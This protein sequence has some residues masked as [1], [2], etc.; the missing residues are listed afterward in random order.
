MSI[1]FSRFNKFDL[2]AAIENVLIPLPVEMTFNELLDAHAAFIHSYRDTSR[3][4]K[5]TDAFGNLSAWEIT[6]AQ[7]N[8]AAQAMLDA[9]Y[10]PATVNRDVSG[11]GSCYR[12]AIKHHKAPHGFVSPT[13]TCTRYTETPRI[14]DIDQETLERLRIISKTYRDKRFAVY[15]HLL[16]DTGA[17]AG[18]L[19]NRKWSD[20]NNEKREILVMVTKTDKPRVLFYSPQTAKLIDRYCP[21]KPDDLLIFGSERYP[22][23]PKKYRDNWITLTKAAGCPGLHQ[24]DLRHNRAR[25][26]L[27]NG[28]SLPVASQIM[29]HSSNMLEK[30]YGHLNNNDRKKAAEL[31]W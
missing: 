15:V 6:T 28:V 2:S 12:W 19:M 11:I 27:V 25:E 30:R 5:W 1:K 10:K 13:R 3:L 21:S 20:L 16:I 29:G 14:V 26:L 22:T 9:G 31:S 7:L 24:H 18:E 4:A 8:R 23:Q 17:R